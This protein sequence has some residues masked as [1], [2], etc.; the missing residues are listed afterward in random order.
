MMRLSLLELVFLGV[1]LGVEAAAGIRVEKFGDFAEVPV[2]AIRPKGHLEEFLRRQAEG[3]TG[4][5]EKLGYPFNTRLWEG[6][7]ERVFFTEGVY[8]GDDEPKDC[9]GEEFWK[10]GMWWP[11]EQTAYQLDGMMRVAQF[12]EAPELE[13]TVKR[14]LEWVYAH[15]NPT[16]GDL[17]ASLSAS[18]SQWPLVVFFRAAMAYAEKTGDWN[19][20]VK[21]FAANYAGKK[22]VRADWKDRDL[23]NVEGMLKVMEFTQ[24]ETLLAD[25]RAMYAKSWEAKA[26]GVKKHIVQH[27]VSLSEMLKIPCLLYLYTGEQNYLDQAKSAVE[28]VYEMD[29][30]ADGLF[31]ANEYT[32]GRDPRQG[33]ETCVTADMMWTL[34]Y[35]LQADGDVKMADRMERIAY[36]A[37]PGSCTK[38]F[39]RHQYLSSVNQAVCGPFA[40]SAHF[41]YGESTWRQYRRA[42][43]PQC[44]TG[45]INRA[46]P[47]FVRRMWLTD[48]ASGSPVAMLYGPSEFTGVQ[49]GVPYTIVEETNYPFEDAV[50]FTLK[51]ER[52]ISVSLRCRIPGWCDSPEAGTLVTRTLES[53][54]TL[55]VNL[56]VRLQVESDRNWHWIRRGPLTF[57]FVPPAMVTEDEPGDP[58][59][60]L[61]IMPEAGSWN[62]AFDQAE[63]KDAVAKAKVEF[64]PAAYPFETP[65]LRVRLPVRRIREWQVLDEG[66]F[67]PDPPLCVHPTGER[68]E[69]DFVP[70]ATT[71]QRITCFPDTEPRERLATVAAYCNGELFP[72]ASER[73]LAE[74][75]FPPETWSDKDFRKLYRVP[76]R[77]ADL[78]F[79][80]G[81]HFAGQDTAGKMTYLLFRVWSDRDADEAV[82]CLSA[83]YEVQAFI[84]GREVYRTD[85]MTE[86]LRMAPSWIKHP[87]KKGYNYMLVKLA[88]PAYV[89]KQYPQFWGAKLEVFV[90]GEKE[91]SAPR[92]ASF[93]DF[94]ATVVP[95]RGV[96]DFEIVWQGEAK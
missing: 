61:R 48:K 51:S 96:C 52:P 89:T 85:G 67:M 43:F 73:A 18:P 17:F 11:Y 9:E 94:D 26:F 57:S 75:V 87:V 62:Y 71:L 47:S 36:N 24:D 20:L 49:N 66:R 22:E 2:S 90:A 58:F 88:R 34:G 23:L 10:S 40:Q 68:A 64:L 81:A 1:F 91:A 95:D 92:T 69:L 38:D 44:C 53:G 56:P 27:G 19:P 77:Q 84:D 31:S 54:K 76:P 65:S 79:D 21:A 46:M 33:H 28:N 45:N 16:N 8:N 15:A 80:L 6:P 63:I 5:P 13:A 32:S 60:A 37:L 29:E 4:H 86:G 14:N 93:A 50:R 74:Q 42:H 78:F 55:E 39:K 7:L 3:I 82:W 35:F 25:A 83:G 12:I 70:Y 72:Y 30:Q 41:N 59:T